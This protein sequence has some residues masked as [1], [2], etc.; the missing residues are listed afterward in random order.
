MAI[1]ETSLPSSNLDWARYDTETQI[2]TI[3][4]DSGAVYEYYDVPE[5]M[6]ERLFSAGSHGSYHYHNIR[7]NYTYD[8][9]A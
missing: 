4:F 7:C 6:V 1:I 5:F 8:R 2:L 9:V 3:G